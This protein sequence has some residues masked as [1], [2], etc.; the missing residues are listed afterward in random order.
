MSWRFRVTTQFV[1]HRLGFSMLLTFA[2]VDVSLLFMSTRNLRIGIIGGGSIVR[3]RHM[4]GL[5]KIDGVEVTAVCN[6][7]F[8]ST[9]RFAD[10]YKIARTADHWRQIIDMDDLDII[11]IGTTPYM[12]CE[13]TLAALEAGKHVFC[14]SRMCL[15]LD[16]AR[17]MVAAGAKHP[18]RIVRFCPPPV[19]LAGDRTMKRLLKKESFV[20]DIRQITLTSVT[21][22]LLDPATPLGWRLQTEQSGQ[23]VLTLGIYLEVLDRWFGPTTR[24]TAVNRTWTTTRTH[25]TTGQAAPAD[26]PESVN[27]IAE[28]A[29]G[30]IGTYLFNGVSSHG[31]S[32]HLAVHGTD[33]TIV[34]DF[35][36]DE[37]KEQLEGAKRSEEQMRSIP[38]SDEERR[39]WTV[40]ADFIHAVRTGQSDPILPDL[41]AGFRYM[42]LI[43]AVH[44]SATTGRLV[45]VP[46]A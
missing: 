31:P 24:V 10:E 16:E 34:Y 15:N 36:A 11:W 9:Q 44:R 43:D 2:R 40:E 1:I 21:G 12:H 18:D 8:E 25:P 6:R 19:G 29:N 26:L 45:Q 37:T 13:I 7:T 20:G 14:Q 28:L 33:G 46:T 4:P 39:V 22:V 17:Q 35:N 38:L 32:D 5:A 3:Q 23:N 41:Q 30:A 27:V 42:A